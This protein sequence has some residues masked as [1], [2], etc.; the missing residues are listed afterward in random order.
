ML[1]CHFDE[2][3]LDCIISNYYDLLGQKLFLA[4]QPKLMDWKTMA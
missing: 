3:P 1:Q 2:H 4:T